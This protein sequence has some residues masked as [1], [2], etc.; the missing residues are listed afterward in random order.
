MPLANAIDYDGLQL[1]LQV[2]NE[3]GTVG[4]VPN[5][6]LTYLQAA[7]KLYDASIPND[8]WSLVLT[9]AMQVTIVDALKGIFNPQARVGEQ[10]QKGLMGKDTAGFARWLLDQN[11]P[12]FTTGAQG[13]TPVISATANQTG[14][15]ITTTGWSTGTQVLNKGDIVQFGGCFA[16]NYVGKQSLPYLAQW[17]VTANV[18]SD[19]SGNATIPIA[20]PDGAGIITSGAT[21]NA[22]AS[23]TA[24]TGVVYVNAGS[25]GINGGNPTS[26]AGNQ[27]TGRGLAY[28][29]SFAAFGCADLPLFD[30]LDMA[31]RATDDQL[32]LSI[33]LIS[34]YDI[35]TDR[36]PTRLDLLGGWAVLYPQMAVRVTS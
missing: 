2:Y 24:S 27:T 1:F 3:V 35:N 32:G 26:S 23:P 28:H 31:E 8:D 20:G 11:C 10:Y 16:V 36:R 9:P 13:G 17:V 22:S 5:A 33:R 12:V 19:G 14:S 21:Q 15:S 4:T 30:G 6:L 7:Q 18:T 34:A 29:K 25:S